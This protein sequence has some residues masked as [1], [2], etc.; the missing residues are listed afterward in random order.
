MT[1]ELRY[2]V[3]DIGA[4]WVGVLAS[5]SGLLKVTLPQNSRREAERQLGDGIKEAVRA[6]GF[7]TDLL[8]RLGDYFAGHRVS[9]NDELDLSAST[10]F[11]RRVWQLARLIPYGETRS[12]GWLAEQLGKAGAGRAV[13]QALARNPLPVIVPCHRVVA[14]DGK[15]GGYSG[16]VAKKR[17]LIRLE[18]AANQGGYLT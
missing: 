6:D 7:F 1:G 10:A 11:Q 14:K 9:F 5:D 18:S 13:G 15:L 3:S 2:T 12:Y 17:Y 8:E 16:G 4:G